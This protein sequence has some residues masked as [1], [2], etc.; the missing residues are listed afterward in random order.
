VRSKGGFYIGIA[1]SLDRLPEECAGPLLARA[2]ESMN[3]VILSSR[4]HKLTKAQYVMFLLADM[5]TWSEVGNVL[6]HKA[7]VYKGAQDRS[8]SFLKAAA[9]LF[10]RE[11]TEK[12]YVNGLKIIC[13]CGQTIDKTAERLNVL[14]L[15]LLMKDHLK[16]MDLIS[17]ELLA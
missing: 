7:A 2:V 3:E 8:P 10:A 6:C 17:S 11:V 15:D 12:V 1:E 9:R 5:I 4:K 13:G 16:D 14:N